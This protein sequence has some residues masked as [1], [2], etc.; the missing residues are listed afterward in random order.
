M[1]QLDRRRFLF[2]IAAAVAAP[3]SG[4]LLLGCSR[5]ATPLEQRFLDHYGY[6]SIDR[7]GLR[8]FL[9]DYQA[10]YGSLL[11]DAVEPREP[12]PFLKFLASSDFFLNGGDESKLVRYL[13]IRDP[14]LNPCFYP[15]PRR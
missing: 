8:R 15:F 11:T 9:A 10:A 12:L 14:Y 5:K 3:G 1:T 4:L 6:L 2:A 13:M 7:E